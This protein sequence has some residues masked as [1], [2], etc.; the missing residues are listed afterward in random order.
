MTA[1][2]QNLDE[3]FVI[4]S[5]TS[6]RYFFSNSFSVYYI[7]LVL[8]CSKALTE[9]KGVEVGVSLDSFKLIDEA[10]SKIPAYRTRASRDNV[11]TKLFRASS[12]TVS[13]F[14]Q[15]LLTC[16]SDVVVTKK[17][18]L[19]EASNGLDQTDLL[20]GYA[21]STLPAD[22]VEGT[23]LF[24][25]YAMSTLPAADAVE[26]TAHG[27][28]FLTSLLGGYAMPLV[29]QGTPLDWTATFGHNSEHYAT[30]ISV[31]GSPSLDWLATLSHDRAV[32]GTDL[33]VGADDV[34]GAD[35]VVGADDVV[36]ADNVV[37]TD[38]VGGT[39]LC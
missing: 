25:G 32:E 9:K 16:S 31:Q 33:V 23:D 35:N 17:L 19:C 28:D 21:M 15:R 39:D 22:A 1:L 12:S 4:D 38:D 6:V 2:D 5:D 29:G 37:G 14:R 30:L 13:R 24:G 36:G 7:D 27:T 8:E 11:L 10:I 18:R 3:L 26:G 20:G 34:V